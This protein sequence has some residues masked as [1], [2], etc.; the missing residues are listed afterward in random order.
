MTAER[1]I[2]NS[3][4]VKR[5][6]TWKINIDCNPQKLFKIDSLSDLIEFYFEEDIIFMIIKLLSKRHSS[7]ENEQFNAKNLSLIH[8]NKALCFLHF[9]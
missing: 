3:I 4:L 2:I 5:R 6:P 8:D 1:S 7:N 9:M